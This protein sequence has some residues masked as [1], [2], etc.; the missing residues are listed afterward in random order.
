MI[1]NADG[2][3][4]TGAKAWAARQVAEWT[5]TR[6]CFAAGTPLRTPEGSRNIEDIRVGDLVLSR[7]EHNPDGLVVAQTVEE[8]FV[9]QGLIWHLHLGGQVIRTTAEHP[10]Y[11]EGDGWTACQELRV[12]DRLLTEDGTW[13]M[14]EDLLDT[15]EWETVY[16]LRVAEFHTYFVGCDEWGFSV[17][18]H[19]MCTPE[20]VQAQVESLV[21]GK[22]LPQTEVVQ[23]KLRA[24]A[25][26]VNGG[27]VNRNAVRLA[28][29]DLAKD[30]GGSVSGRHAMGAVEDLFAAAAVPRGPVSP[31]FQPVFHGTED[32]LP[33]FHGTSQATA[34]DILS[35]GPNLGKSG[36]FLDFGP[37]FYTQRTLEDARF[38][39]TKKFKDEAAVV[40]F[41]L[42]RAG[43]DG[44]VKK[45]FGMAASP[46]WQEFVWQGRSGM[47]DTTLHGFDVVAGPMIIRPTKM[48]NS[49]ASLVDVVSKG[50]QQSWATPAA[51]RVLTSRGSKLV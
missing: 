19:N 13:V 6:A 5:G 28:V 2:T 8:V 15:G 27:E 26:L 17:W 39:A 40:Q 29:Q 51:I 24:V 33:L 35:H 31:A 14:V 7:D 12:G 25:D 20:M 11:R 23:A 37:G 32:V 42:E 22:R 16:N 45:D 4:K 43:L 18:A 36:Q 10:F 34:A 50:D 48:P 49:P 21:A 1:H 44:L 41:D 46:A 30:A 47:F 9:R 38:W 3:E